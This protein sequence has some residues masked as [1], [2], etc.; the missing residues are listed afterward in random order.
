MITGASTELG[1]NV[2]GAY[3]STGEASGNSVTMSD[4]WVKGSIWGAGSGGAKDASDNTVIIR[5]G[6][7]GTDGDAT[8]GYI[9]GGT[10]DGT[11][12]A[13][14]NTVFISGASTTVNY[15]ITAAVA[16]NGDAND[17]TAII[18]G[19]VMR[20]VVGARVTTA[21][22]AERNT[23]LIEGGTFS[24]GSS[25]YGGWTNTGDATGN[26]VTVKGGT[27][28]QHVAGGRTDGDGT[29]S[30][31]VVNVLG[32]VFNNAANSEITGGVGTNNSGASGGDAINNT[33]KLSGSPTLRGVT[34]YG[35]NSGG[36]ADA[37]SGNILQIHDYSGTEV[38]RIA[39]FETYDFYISASLAGG[40][41]ALTVTDASNISDSVT[42][43]N[44]TPGSGGLRAGDQIT[45]INDIG[46]LTANDTN[47]Y[48][49]ARQGIAVIYGLELS[50][51]ANNRY[52]RVRSGQADPQSKPLAEGQVAS[53]AFLGQGGDLLAGLNRW[54]PA[55]FDLEN[56][57]VGWTPFM[58][59]SGG[60][61]RYD[62]GSHVDV[63]G[64]SLVAGLT[65]NHPVAEGLL[66]AGPF[67]EFGNGNYDTHNSFNGLESIAGDGDTKYY[68]GGLIGRYDLASGLYFEALFR[69]GRVENE[70]NSADLSRLAGTRA[71]YDISSTYYGAQAAMG[72]VWQLNACTSLDFTTRY[73]WTHQDGQGVTVAGDRFD[74]DDADS[75]RWRN[76]LRLSHA[77]NEQFIPYIGAAFDYEF[78]GRADAAVYGYSVDAPE[79]KGG[80]G[81]GELGFSLKPAVDSG[82]SLDLSV[83]GYTGVREGVTGNVQLKWEF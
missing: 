75:H 72:Y 45:L 76:G 4:G 42:R 74:F 18:S 29:A 20:G 60:S 9:Y 8:T 58:T 19:G 55:S 50:N 63:D 64:V 17:N 2:R 82:F 30:N 14:R 6:K 80:T 31:N 3:A 81:I 44:F 32:G 23:V 43:V 38:R 26:T 27:D 53:L 69:A 12:K 25:I 70:F 62:S 46:G 1:G 65:W 21:G 79:L 10:N 66:K 5:G 36:A 68:G 78:D 51:D 16:T 28:L 39:N 34:I 71:H 61:S 24:S 41:A 49:Q 48:A 77:V 7:I 83:Q 52:A 57:E 47:T 67:F 11:G 22:K 15:D 56:L 13:E 35:G 54:S 33:V 37:V 40:G 59:V 73:L